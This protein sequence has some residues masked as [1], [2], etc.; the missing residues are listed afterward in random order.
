[1]GHA[2]LVHHKP[3]HSHTLY[4]TPHT[5]MVPGWPQRHLSL[6]HLLCCFLSFS[7]FPDSQMLLVKCFFIL[8]QNSPVKNW[9][10]FPGKMNGLQ[11]S[12]SLRKGSSPSEQS[13]P[14]LL[15]FIKPGPEGRRG[16]CCHTCAHLKSSF[17]EHFCNLSSSCNCFSDV[18]GLI[19]LTWSI[20]LEWIT[21]FDFSVFSPHISI[22]PISLFNNLPE[23]CQAIDSNCHQ[24]RLQ[25][26]D[27][28]DNLPYF[29]LIYFDP[30]LK[31]EV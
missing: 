15:Y 28:F 29:L 9:L 31:M 10:N 20:H 2:F 23:R 7:S 6:Q 19:P 1:M 24:D 22:S 18:T 16:L 27:K 14:V 25:V 11:S 3:H 4:L 5:F 13:L 26:F 21:R 30:F 12:V 17:Y 8:L